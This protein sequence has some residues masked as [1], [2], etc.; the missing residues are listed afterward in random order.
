MKGRYEKEKPPFSYKKAI[1][2]GVITILTLCVTLIAAAF[3]YYQ[4]MLKKINHVSVPAIL[5]TTTAE[6]TTP[7]SSDDSSIPAIETTVPQEEHIPSSAD[8]INFLLVGQA[9]R[10]GEAERFAD[11]MILCTLNTYKKTLTITSMLRDTLVK[12]PNY[13]GHTG[14]NIKL[15]TIY[16]LGYVYGSGISGSMELMNQTLYDNFGIEVDYD[17]EVDFD[18][19]IRVIDKLG[20]IDIELTQ[21]EADYLN[22]DDF[23]VYQDVEPGMAHL[24]GMSTLCY[25]RMRKAAGDSDSDITRTSRQRK[26]MAILL[27]KFKAMSP[28][29]VQSLLN[30][31][32]P[33]IATSMD[34]DEITQ[35]L[36]TLLPIL[37]E[38][39]IQSSG[40][41]PAD[42]W[43]EMLDIYSNG[44]YHSVLRYDK[45]ET[46]KLMRAI[47]EGESQ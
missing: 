23:W 32:L 30:E 8:Y 12:M 15:T 46:K 31:I 3:W 33:L 43:G 26:V 36:V 22:A 47:T 35:M 9:A 5:Y 39:H 25:A 6:E 2:I 40:T 34:N 38:L 28:L 42:Y 18:A 17:F 20:G 29:K 44:M 14:G 11:T 10:D 19:F 37:P 27:D 4:S 7:V 41:C 45:E 13:R 24:D 1:K 16:H 21:A